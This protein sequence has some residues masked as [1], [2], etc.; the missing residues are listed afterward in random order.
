MDGDFTYSNTKAVRIEETAT[1]AFRLFPNPTSEILI[2]R[3]VYPIDWN[4]H[5]ILMFNSQGNK[6]LF[7]ANQENEQLELFVE[8]LANGLYFIVIQDKRNG[9]IIDSSTFIKD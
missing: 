8:H 2:L 6:I 4:T 3:P 9:A 5:E 1:Q 7:N